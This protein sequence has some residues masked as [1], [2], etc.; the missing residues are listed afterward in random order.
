M[1]GNSIVTL[2]KERQTSREVLVDGLD[3][4]L[5]AQIQ[6]EQQ[7]A[8]QLFESARTQDAKSVSDGRTH[9]ER[10]YAAPEWAPA[11]QRGYDQGRER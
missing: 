6:D 1:N 2:I 8:R 4:R 5:K 7:K 11:P 3:I 10:R 9:E